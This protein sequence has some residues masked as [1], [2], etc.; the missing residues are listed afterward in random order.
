MCRVK[1]CASPGHQVKRERARGPT[2]FDGQKYSER[3]SKP[4]PSACGADDIA[5]NPSELL[6]RSEL[7]IMCGNRLFFQ[8]NPLPT[9]SVPHFSIVSLLQKPCFARTSPGFTSPPK[10]NKTQLSSLPS[11]FSSDVYTMPTLEM[12]C[13]PL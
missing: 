3:G 9:I 4:R 5:T 2:W 7:S 8:G 10:C 11:L 6:G 13:A 12:L 1:K